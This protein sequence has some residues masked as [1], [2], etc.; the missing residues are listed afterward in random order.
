VVVEPGQA[1]G[2]EGHTGH[3]VG[4]VDRL[5]GAGGPVPGADEPAGHLQHHRVVGLH[6]AEREGGHQDV[7]RLGPVVFVVVGGEQAVGGA[8]AHVL[9]GGPDVLGEPLLVG[10]VGDQVGVGDHQDV[11]PVQPAH[12]DRSVGAHQLH[13]LLDGGVSGP[14]GGDVHD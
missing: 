8:G 3:V 6:R 12:Q 9:Q 13:D 1:D 7:V 2:V 5:P 10:E 14:G 4:D 11:A